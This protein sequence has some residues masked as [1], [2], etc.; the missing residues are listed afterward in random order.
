MSKPHQN[1]G[2]MPIVI[3]AGGMGTRLREET[4]YKPKPMVEIGERPVLWHIMKYFSAYGFN[5]FIICLGYKGDLI[6]DYF[7]NYHTRNTNLSLNLG[8]PEPA[9]FMDAHSEDEWKVTLVDTG[10]ESPTGERLQK[11]R[12]FIGERTFF[13][14]YGDGLADVDLTQLVAFHEAHDGIGTLSA[15]HPTSRFGVVDIEQDGRIAEFH[16]KP[17]VDDWINGGFMILEPSV[18]EYMGD[19]GPFEEKPLRALASSKNLFAFKH[20]K[21]WQPMDTYREFLLLNALWSEGK[22]PWKIW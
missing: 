9:T 22:A 5:D 7:L 8:S 12:E 6:R 17:I 20:E 11:V 15:V 3:L 10:K 19:G 1:P 18:F 13:Y 21:F 2:S 16:E 14:T 4:E